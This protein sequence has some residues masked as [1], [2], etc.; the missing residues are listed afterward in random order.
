MTTSETSGRTS[1]STTPPTRIRRSFWLATSPIG[2]KKT[3]RVVSPFVA[4]M[5]GGRAANAVVVVRY[6][7]GCLVVRTIHGLI[8]LPRP[9]SMFYFPTVNCTNHRRDQRRGSRGARGSTERPALQSVGLDAGLLAWWVDCAGMEFCLQTR[10]D[11]RYALPGGGERL[12][13]G[14]ECRWCEDWHLYTAL[15]TLMPCLYAGTARIDVNYVVS[16]VVRVCDW[17]TG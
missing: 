17:L 8:P 5:G 2:K 16:K 13:V 1:P 7:I 4:F 12:P 15:E 3:V 14:V 6:F 9:L 10:T 11:G